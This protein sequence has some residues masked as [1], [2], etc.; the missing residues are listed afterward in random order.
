MLRNILAKLRFDPRPLV[1]SF[2]A[3][4]MLLGDLGDLSFFEAGFRLGGRAR[5]VEV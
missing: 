1:E 4:T 5:D 3:R 2:E